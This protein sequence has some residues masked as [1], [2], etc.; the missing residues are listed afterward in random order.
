ML[1]CLR[2]GTYSKF[3]DTF[4]VTLILLVVP[5]EDLSCQFISRSTW[6]SFR[7]LPLND[8]PSAFIRAALREQIPPIL[9]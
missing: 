7:V 8:R 5:P 4:L 2:F 1:F 6:Y 3:L 9:S